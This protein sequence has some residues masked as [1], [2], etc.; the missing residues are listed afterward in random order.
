MR[1]GHV[2][3][4]FCPH[5]TKDTLEMYIEKAID[6]GYTSISFTEHAPLP[7]SFA[8]PT[9]EKDS[10]MDPSFLLDYLEELHRLRR[11][12]KKQIEIEVGLEVDY[13]EGFEQETTDFLKTY[14]HYLTD[15]LLSV[16][17]LKVDHD[18][19]CLDFSE[20]SFS[21]LTKRAGSIEAVYQLYYQTI[22][23]AIRA[24]LGPY[25]PKRLGHLTLVRK[26][27]LL[28]PRPSIEDHFIDQ[29]LEE[30][31]NAKMTLDYNGAGW[32]KT[33]CKETYPSKDIAR[34][35][36]Q[37]GIPL[38]YGSDAHQSKDLKQG[39]DQ[40]DTEVLPSL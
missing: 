10:G 2:H 5:G 25:K 31:K 23:K 15:S 39:W 34:K 11:R 8:D 19:F 9:P 16:H 30:V 18:Y 37:M 4:P 26:F 20:E 28:Y 13:I 35:A 3:S 7:S 21:D 33:H 17:F 24:N 32:N 29:A 40:L 14:G 36:Y 1:D 22:S 6:L 12:Y 38:I 27:Q